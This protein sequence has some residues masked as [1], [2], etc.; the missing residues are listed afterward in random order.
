MKKDKQP[1]SG[2]PNDHQMYVL[3]MRREKQAQKDAV[4]PGRHEPKT[5][6]PNRCREIAEKKGI[7]GY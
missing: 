3:N 4:T 2:S 1:V 7:K 6:A 5:Q